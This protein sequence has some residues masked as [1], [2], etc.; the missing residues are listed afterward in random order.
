M[1]GRRAYWMVMAGAVMVAS[2]AGPAASRGASPEEAN[3]RQV[4]ERLKTTRIISIQDYD[5]INAIDQEGMAGVW[6]DSPVKEYDR[7]YRPRLDE[8]LGI[9]LILVRSDELLAEMAKVADED[10]ERLADTWIRE[11]TEMKHVKRSDVVRPAY[12][13]FAFKAL[14]KKY[15]AAAITYDSAT[16]TGDPGA[17]QGARPLL[18]PEPRRL[19]GDAGDRRL[20]DRRPAGLHG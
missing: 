10:A 14:V 13:Y 12:L 11:A 6:G 9:K 3:A 5:K 17:R 19:P 20:A 18:L 4:V 15:D 1:Y 8:Y 7:N 2:A 16:L